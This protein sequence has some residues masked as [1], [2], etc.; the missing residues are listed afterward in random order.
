M[1]MIERRVTQTRNALYERVTQDL[2]Q[3]LHDVCLDLSP[4]EFDALV[5]RAAIIQIKYD[6]RFDARARDN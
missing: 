4:D 1:W 3:R 6:M 5:Q 2:R